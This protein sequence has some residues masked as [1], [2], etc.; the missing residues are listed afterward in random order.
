MIRGVN[1]GSRCDVAARAC[2]GK[3]S[4]KHN[5][6]RRTPARARA[7]RAWGY[8][9]SIWQRERVA[10]ADGR[11]Y[12][13]RRARASGRPAASRH[14]LLAEARQGVERRCQRRR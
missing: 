12:E 1:W 11:R 3:V 6:F 5:V 8:Q 9:H 14:K 4:V 13:P 7:Q 2:E 10:R